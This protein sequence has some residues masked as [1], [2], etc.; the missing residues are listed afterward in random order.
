MPIHIDVH[1]LANRAEALVLEQAGH[2]IDG[3]EKRDRAVDA[4][5]AWVDHL[6]VVGP[7]VE[8]ALLAIVRLLAHGIIQH[9]YDR[10]H[11]A[12]KV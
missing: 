9:A 10:L 5:V 6:N 11:A 1:A 7:A 12:G 2:A 8:P 4:L 3:S